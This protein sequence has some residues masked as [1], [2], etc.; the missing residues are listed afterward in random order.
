M[1]GKE[2]YNYKILTM[3]DFLFKYANGGGVFT[4]EIVKNLKS[5]HATHYDIG[6]LNWPFLKRVPFEVVSK[7]DLLTGQ[8]L[9]VSDFKNKNRVAPYIRPELLIEKENKKEKER[10]R[11]R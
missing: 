2:I 10:G 3:E 4:K 6:L 9:L 5:A 11:K 8:V 1:K 7:D